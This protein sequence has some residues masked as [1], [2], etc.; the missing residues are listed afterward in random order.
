M[1]EVESQENQPKKKTTYIYFWKFTILKFF[2]GV[3]VDFFQ[4]TKKIHHQSGQTWKSI[5]V[6]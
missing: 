5:M 6:F 4:K 2:L 3:K 1:L